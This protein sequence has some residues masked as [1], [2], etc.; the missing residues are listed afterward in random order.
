MSKFIKYIQLQLKVLFKS[1]DQLIICLIT[2][3][4]ILFLF[5]YNKQKSMEEIQ[6]RK[7]QYPYSKQSLEK[8][9]I[10]GKAPNSEDTLHKNFI[11][12]KVN[13][14]AF[15]RVYNISKEL[16]NFGSTFLL[17]DELDS[18]KYYQKDPLQNLA[19]NPNDL[20]E[21][22]TS[23]TSSGGKIR[24]YRTG[25]ENL[26][27]KLIKERL[28]PESVRYGCSG[29]LFLISI[30]RYISSFIGLFVVSWCGIRKI[31]NKYEG[32]QYKLF[33]TGFISKRKIIIGDYLVFLINVLIFLIMITLFSLI[34]TTLFGY[35][36][37][38]N[39]PIITRIKNEITLITANEYLFKFFAIYFFVISILFFFCYFFSLLLKS[40]FAG[41]LIATIVLA[42]GFY[43]GQLLPL[44]SY[45]PLIYTQPTKNLIGN[46][47]RKIGIDFTFQYKEQGND[48]EY[49][50][51][52]VIFENTSY[53]QG[54]TL[55]YKL[56]LNLS[57]E[58]AIVSL[59]VLYLILLV[60]STIL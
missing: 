56:S 39:Y 35:K 54:E 58:K 29:S 49:V 20:N 59:M 14:K 5:F 57:F 50:T 24:L 3:L 55:G 10:K 41:S 15:N 18:L 32:N 16:K 47:L 53:Y 21:S 23:F 12:L 60:I 52:D 28:E 48:F 43:T 42:G 17:K 1:K 44:S 4:S 8:L 38:G 31:S 46:D 26:N 37:R 7:E 9:E 22:I 40:G 11:E 19:N 34:I 6:F 45:N 30:S 2:L 25:K 33:K 27:S 51:G 36:F 13:S